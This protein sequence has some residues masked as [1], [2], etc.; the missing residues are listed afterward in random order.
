MKLSLCIIVKNEAENLPTLFESIVDHVDQ[1]VVTDTGSI[2]GTK[3]VCEEYC[4]DKLK[5]TEFSWC[6]DFSAARAFNFS[7]ADGEWIVWADADDEIVG[8]EN[9]KKE[10]E[11]WGPKGVNSFVFPYHYV[12]DVH[13]NTRV[14]QPRERLITNDGS[15]KWVGKLHEALTPLGKG[16]KA[17]KLQSVQWYHRTN[18][19]RVEHAAIRNVSIL[20]KAMEEEIKHDTIDP[21]TV[22]NLGNAYF[23]N[24][25]FLKAI[26]C[27]QKYIP[28]SGWGEEIYLARWRSAAALREL[29]RYE[30]AKEE[31]LLAVKEKPG[32]PDAFIELGK[33]CMQLGEWG[34][35][36]M[37]FKTAESREFPQS[38]PVTSPME[39][40]PH[41]WWHKGHCLVQL[42]RYKE[43]LP[44]FKKYLQKLPDDEVVQ[45]IIDVIETQVAEAEDVKAIMRVGELV[46]QQTFWHMLPQ[47]YLKYPEVLF[48][49]NQFVSRETTTGKDIALF[50]GE[51]VSE[52]DPTCEEEGGIG[53]SEEA[54]INMARGLREKGWNVHV[55]GTPKKEGD[56]GGVLY[57][58]W[59]QFNPNDAWDIFIAWRIPQY[60]HS[61]INAKKKYLWLHDVTTIKHFT[62]KSLEA[63]D[64]IFVLSQFHR[65]LLPEIEDDKF[66]LTGNGIRIDQFLEGAQKNKMYCINTSA[67]DRGLECLLKMWPKV[68]EQVPEAELHWFYGWE[69]F[70]GLT[71]HR[72]EKKAEKERIVK[73]LDQP[74]VFDEGRVDHET[75]AKKYEEAQLWVYPTEF[76]EIYCITADKAQ[77]GGALPV[78]TNVAAVGERVQYGTKID[79]DDIYTNEEAQEKFVETV[80]DYLK[81]PRQVN[82]EREGMREYAF[83]E[84]SW[85]NIINQWDE[86]FINDLNV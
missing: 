35:A 6:D 16:S 33:T 60:V 76:S 46:G 49:K 64:K 1:V 86:L 84:Y 15:F 12:V 83:K 38:A 55:F 13:G 68:R 82:L 70:D 17:V 24:G 58:H 65:D 11:E 73:L 26:A 79:A 62:D 28:L 34:D 81:N 45:R 48:E 50:C 61:G 25:Q 52:W 66:V 14:L 4:G 23:T 54:A 51:A 5:W 29:K 8:A 75:I 20:E 37:W 3:E 72:P 80:V 40:G 36:L 27:Y 85:E 56:Y 7:Q 59:T 31:A 74:G 32:H 53:G 9:L 71:A 47:R 10:I 42:E 19:E 77:A 78:T 30:E 43:A 22:Y 63:V 2:D 69:T 44:F 39:Y 21:R 57:H 67:P 41:M 18:D